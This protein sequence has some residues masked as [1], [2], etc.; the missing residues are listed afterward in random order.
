V[1]PGGRRPG[2]ADT[3]QEIIRAAR[4]IFAT[5]GYDKASLRAIA[6]KAL[7]DAALVHHYFDG[8]AELFI[9][10]MAMPFDPRQVKEES[11]AA[12]DSTYSGHR[13]VEGFLT[14]WDRAEGTGS[15]FASCVAGM[16]A[17]T[18]V[19][20]AIREF[21]NER[22]WSTNKA[23]AGEDEDTFKIRRSMVSSQLMGLAFNRYILRVPPLSTA[24]PAEIAGWA[25]PT[26]NRY[27]YEPLANG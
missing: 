27:V 19:A 12:S 18:S 15:S 10:A 1:S 23:L 7:V 26:L 6:R 3:R 8:K 14:M 25:G 13:V 16:V 11:E 2:H 17:S 24:T 20:D 21:V 4:E 5:C 22:V 9:A